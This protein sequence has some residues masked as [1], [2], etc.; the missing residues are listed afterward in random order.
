MTQGEL[1]FS[2]RADAQAKAAEIRKVREDLRALGPAGME[3]AR[4]VLPL[5]NAL[6]G[7]GTGLASQNRISGPGRAALQKTSF[8]LLRASLAEAQEQLAQVQA[9]LKASWAE[10]NGDV[11]PQPTKAED[12]A[13]QAAFALG[14][15]EDSAIGIA[16]AGMAEGIA[17]ARAEAV[18]ADGAASHHPR[19][20]VHAPA[21]GDRQRG[22]G[23]GRFDHNSVAGLSTHGMAMQ[24]DLGS[25]QAAVA[26]KVRAGL[27]TVTDGQDAMARAKQQRANRLADRKAR[28]VGALAA[29]D[30]TMFG[31][32]RRGS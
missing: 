11:I 29:V 9:L 4:G 15:G 32:T 5:G 27:M 25:A 13:R 16:Q 23:D 8:Q 24:A 18:G 1:S 21:H 26:E 30:K 22:A 6:G 28:G 31:Q 10:L 2:V 20:P 3:A 7:A 19:C 14:E 12:L 17:A